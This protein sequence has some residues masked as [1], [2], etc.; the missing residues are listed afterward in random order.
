MT[1]LKIRA[2]R[3]KSDEGERYLLQVQHKFLFFKWWETVKKGSNGIW[4]YGNAIFTIDTTEKIRK[5]CEESGKY[6]FS[7]ETLTRL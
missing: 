2:L 5:F 1:K 6:E 4:H 7:Y 3:I